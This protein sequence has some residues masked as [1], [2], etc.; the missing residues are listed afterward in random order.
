MKMFLK[1]SMYLIISILI[2]VVAFD[3]VIDLLC[4]FQL[5][6]YDRKSILKKM[7]R[8]GKCGLGYWILYA[9]ILTCFLML[10][11]DEEFILFL[12]LILM[13]VNLIL[14]GKQ[15]QI[16][17]KL[18]YTKR[19]IRLIVV[20][21]ILV[22]VEIFFYLY[23]LP[24]GIAIIMLP[25]WLIANYL[26]VYLSDII[27]I[28]TEYLV[29]RYY[30]SKAKKKL[31][32]NKKLIKIGLTGS[33][34][35][36]TTK[37]ILGSILKE[38]FSVVATPKSFNT[39]FGITKTINSDLKSSDEVF[40]C[41]MGAKRKGEIGY[42]CNIVGVDMGIV[43]SVGRQHMDTFKSLENI[44][45]T[46]K[47]LPDALFGKVCV[48]NLMNVYTQS[49]YAEFVGTKIGVFVCNVRSKVIQNATLY[50]YICY[51]SAI[52][53]NKGK[54]Y[55]FSKKNNYYAKRIKCTE[56]GSNF[57]VFY[58]GKFLLSAELRLI[59]FHNIIN[60][61]LAIAIAHHLGESPT[62]ISTGIR[63][64]ESVS[65]RLEKIILPSGAVV[66]NNGYNANIDSS[67]HAL[68]ILELFDRSN[69]VVITPG[70]VETDND[71]EYN[72]KLGKMIAGVATKVIIVKEKNRDALLKG[73]MVS[74]Y[75]M[76]NVVCVNSFV[77][78]KRVIDV[79]NEDY[80]FLIENDLPDNYI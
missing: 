10:K 24:M 71:Y 50:S 64:L 33:Y 26:N 4:F 15:F 2:G 55:Q 63:K 8:E 69:R 59:G 76:C 1:I 28:P 31:R 53:H 70:I 62:N 68:R 56:N 12:V 16:L 80:V 17:N 46:K 74:D 52:V 27:L 38:S 9:I 34:G 66:I 47:E 6:S 54:Y 23:F 21:V 58:D 22:G 57:D 14:F 11:I 78:A 37:E 3:G 13:G 20:Y 72:L 18:K 40:V 75:D 79:A 44:Y 32:A 30:I 43:T 65:A 7:A 67:P 5:S 41:E 49:M 25:I 73:L 60:C 77:D 35:K 61:L 51:K 36:T 45:K 19:I 42:L 39:P 29:G 48:F